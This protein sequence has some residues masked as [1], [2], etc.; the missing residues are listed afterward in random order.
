MP[1]S[2]NLRER[3]LKMAGEQFLRQ[4]FHRVSMDS[5]VAAL[6][7]SKS[8]I[9]KHFESKEAL[10]AAL[11]DQLDAVINRQL[12]QVIEHP[13]LSFGDKLQQVTRLSSRLAQLVDR[14]FLED[15][16][17]YT[18]DLWELYQQQRSD[19]IDQYYMRMFQQ[20]VDELLV[21]SDIDLRLMVLAYLQLAELTVVP[22]RLGV[23][24]YN[25][26]ELYDVCTAL[27]LEGALLRE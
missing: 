18:P 23:M 8:S 3:I 11:V 26:E 17:I 19:R 7:T 4:G 9:Y 13:G 27:F 5:L 12:E 22:E 10:V 20:G 16:R 24:P 15:L 1:R 21:R 6:R 14:Q 25:Q 2:S